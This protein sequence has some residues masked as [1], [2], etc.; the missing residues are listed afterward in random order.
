VAATGTRL[1]VPT[2]VNAFLTALTD[3]VAADPER[4]AWFAGRPERLAQALEATAT[5]P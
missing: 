1:G 2:P 5:R 4:A 3:E